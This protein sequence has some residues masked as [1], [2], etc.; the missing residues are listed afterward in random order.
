METTIEDEEEGVT[1]Y[2]IITVTTTV[3]SPELKL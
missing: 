3:T 1:Y 2:K